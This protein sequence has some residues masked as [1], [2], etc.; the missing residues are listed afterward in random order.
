V[1]SLEPPVIGPGQEAVQKALRVE[2]LSAGYG[3]RGVLFD[4][5][6]TVEPGQI[7]AVLGH[8]GAGKTTLL[9][10]IVGL[11]AQRSGKVEFFGNDLVHHSSTVNIRRGISFTPATTPVFAPL[12]VQENL[13]LAAYVVGAKRE[14]ERLGFVFDVFPKLKERVAQKAGTLSGGEQRMLA[15]GMALMGQPKVMLLD[16]PS[17]GLSPALVEQM[18]EAIADLCKREGTA[19]LLVE[20]QV[21]AT[22][23]VADYVYFLR[24]GHVALAETA[25]EARKRQDYWDLF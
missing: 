24:M 4:V 16:E 10:A 12:S 1:N 11:V 22:L 25:A 15:I 19:A 23:Q 13:R 18:L 5:D 3:K 17:L 21:P 8:N 14:N 20:Q 7:V 2:S 9:K 6:L